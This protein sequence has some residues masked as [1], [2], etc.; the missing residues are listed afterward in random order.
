MYLDQTNK[1]YIKTAITSELR[2]LSKES[3]AI[4][5]NQNILFDAYIEKSKN[6]DLNFEQQIKCLYETERVND[7]RNE[8][9]NFNK[10]IIAGLIISIGLVVRKTYNKA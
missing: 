8:R 6:P 2:N 9:K 7:K 4:S 5:N 3:V 10:I 1:E